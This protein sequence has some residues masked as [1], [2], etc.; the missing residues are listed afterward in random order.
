MNRRSMKITYSEN[1]Y[2]LLQKKSDHIK[3]GK[4]TIGIKYF[5]A[6]IFNCYFI[7]GNINRKLNPSNIRLTYFL[8]KK[9]T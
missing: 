8:L 9:H 3:I 4:S 2:A 1:S 7:Y 6:N 5:L